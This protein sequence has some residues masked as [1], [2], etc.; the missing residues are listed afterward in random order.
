[1]LGAV[2]RRQRLAGEAPPSPGPIVLGR[3]FGQLLG[4]QPIAGFA[5]D[6]I[7]SQNL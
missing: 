2:G 3:R 5:R 1:V 7:C 6:I 4:G